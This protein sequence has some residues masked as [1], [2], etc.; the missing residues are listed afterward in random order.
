MSS[1]QQRQAEPSQAGYHRRQQQRGAVDPITLRLNRSPEGFA[2]AMQWRLWWR[3]LRGAIA[4]AIA[5]LPGPV[6]RWG[7][8]WRASI[9][10]EWD[11]DLEALQRLVRAMGAE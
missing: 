6:G 10:R 3:D 8:A 1:P 5:H 4:A 9:S 11:R 7:L 2:G